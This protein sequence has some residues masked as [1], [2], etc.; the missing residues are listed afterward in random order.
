[1][2][3]L[4][5]LLEASTGTFDASSALELGGQVLTWILN[6]IKGEPILAC[7]FVLAVLVPAGFGIVSRVKYTAR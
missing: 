5:G 6:V 1:M 7:A 2:G 4:L 3:N